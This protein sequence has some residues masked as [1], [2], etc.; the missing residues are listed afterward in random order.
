M[1]KKRKTI[2]MPS[3]FKQHMDKVEEMCNKYEVTNDLLRKVLIELQEIKSKQVWSYLECDVSTSSMKVDSANFN[4]SGNATIGGN[5][6]V[7]GRIIIKKKW[8]QFWRR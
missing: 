5:L 2:R 4:I 7:K 6:T 3:K 8:W 1:K